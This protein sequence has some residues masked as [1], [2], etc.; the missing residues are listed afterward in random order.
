MKNKLELNGLT[1]QELSEK[2]AEAQKEYN[3]MEF[4]H[5][6]QGLANTGTLVIARRNVARINTE[7]RK[8]E[9][10]KLPENELAQRSKIRA[11]RR[12]SN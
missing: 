2:L 6:A 8:R 12:R 1:D 3:S 7:I 9:L 11:R 10:A 5:N 4:N